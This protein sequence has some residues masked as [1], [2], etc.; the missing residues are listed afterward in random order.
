VTA[1]ADAP[2][3]ADIVQKLFTAEPKIFVR[4][5][6]RPNIHLAIQR[7]LDST[8]RVE[9]MV[10]RHRGKSGIVCCASR[11]STA[12]VP[13]LPYHAGLDATLR[14]AHEDEFLRD[15]GVVIVATGMAGSSLPL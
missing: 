3:R 7:K 1:T 15:D 2:T 11:K 4:S 8:R 5:F 12:G 9:A 10:K 13:A 6:D 14:L